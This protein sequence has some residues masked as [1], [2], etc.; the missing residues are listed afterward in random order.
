MA[1]FYEE[2]VAGMIVHH[3]EKWKQAVS[4]P[5][6][7]GWFVGQVLKACDG[8]ADPAK[9]RECLDAHARDYAIREAE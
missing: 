5:E 3:A 2:A 6:L 8:R 7:R 4:K 1:A 9:V